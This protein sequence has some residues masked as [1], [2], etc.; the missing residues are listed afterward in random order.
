MEIAI[1]FGGKSVEHDVSI[2]TA[3]Q[4]HNMCKNMHN[5]RLIYVDKLGKLNLYTNN[6]FEFDDFKQ[7]N[8]KFVPITLHGGTIYKKGVFGFKKVTKLDC[9][10]MC[11][12]GGDG[13]NGTLSS[14][15]IS[16]GV[17]VTAGNSTALG[18]SMNKWLSKMF[19]KA[20]NIPFVKG[21]YANANTNIDILDNKITGSFGY[22][23]IVK[24]NGGGSSIGIKTATNKTELK[25]ALQVALE[26]D[27]SAVVEQEL[28]DFTEYNCAVLGDQNKA[29]LSKIDEPI[30][31][32][33][34]LSFTDKYLS[35]AKSKKQK[36]SLKTQARNYPNLEA[37][38][39]KK[40]QRLSK[41]IFTKLGFYGVVRIDYIYTPQNKKLYVNEINA[42]P[43][44]LA[45]YYFANTKLEYNLFIDKLI[46]IGI[47]NYKNNA[48]INKDFI[49]KLF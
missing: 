33:K 49:T 42:I 31:H 41:Q 36:G 35:G 6:N 24:A 46:K 45:S 26:F 39:D 15:F 3:K 40:I 7:Q 38:L 32:D 1:V 19:F 4:I 5:T 2:V 8:K 17:A 9:A 37:C 22:P 25:Q 10:I 34:I 18:I 14:L 47:K 48:N 23:V 12:H 20:N 29:E 11:T 27:S 13:E 28:K 43:G 30:K 21:F 44:S 16:Q